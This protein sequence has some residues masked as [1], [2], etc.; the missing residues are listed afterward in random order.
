M[1]QK[2]SIFGWITRLMN[3]MGTSMV[4][5]I[6]LVVLCDVLGR[7]LFKKPLPGTP[8][9]VAMSIAAIVYLQFPS[10]LRAG[11]VISADGLIEVIGKRS[12]RAEQ[13]LQ[14]FHHL[15]GGVMFGIT[16]FFVTKL[17]MKAWASNDFYG[18]VSLFTF[19][20]WPLFAVIA[21]GAFMMTIQYAI[22]TVG[23]IKAGRDGVRLLNID[24]SNKVV[25]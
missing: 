25:S 23:L 4:M 20:K 9:I 18:S 13:W 8:E 12:I 7:F 22:L 1:K 17:V 2:E 14:A 11:R 5:F 15:V 16:S 6:M 3:V 24:P 10:T 21:F 19:P